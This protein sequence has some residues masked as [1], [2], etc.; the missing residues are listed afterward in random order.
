MSIAQLRDWINRHQSLNIAPTN[1]QVLILV[2]ENANLP[3]PDESLELDQAADILLM[4]LKDKYGESAE[5]SIKLEAGA[6]KARFVA[7]VRDKQGKPKFDDIH[8]IPL[9]LWDKLT[10]AEKR[11]I[12]RN[13]GYP[14]KR[15]D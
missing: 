9:V 4:Q 7:I 15:G 5:K 14:S 10:A 6:G 11:E 3:A 13:G 8:G 2:A 12:R 1:K